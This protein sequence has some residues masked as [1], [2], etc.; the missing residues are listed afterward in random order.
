MGSRTVFFTGICLVDN[1]LQIFFGIFFLNLFWQNIV[2]QFFFW[3]K[4]L[5]RNFGGDVSGSF[6]SV[7]F[8]R[9]LLDFF[10]Q[11]F[12][13][14]DFSSQLCWWRCLLRCFGRD[15][16]SNIFWCS[17]LFTD[18]EVQITPLFCSV[19]VFL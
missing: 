2:L 14:R 6:L 11:R 9:D 10:L 15:V 16:F 19:E 1:P 8:F 17:F 18:F 3:W 13:A 7:D 5:L 4:F 12:F